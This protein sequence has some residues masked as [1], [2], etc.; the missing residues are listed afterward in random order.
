VPNAGASPLFDSAKANLEHV[1]QQLEEE[2]QRWRDHFKDRSISYY[3]RGKE[4]FQ[5]ELKLE[6]ISRG[7]VPNIFT[8]SSEAKGFKRFYTSRIRDLVKIH[9]DASEEFAEASMNVLRDIIARFDA[10]RDIWS[11]LVKSAAEVDALIGLAVA[12]L[13]DGTGPMVRPVVLPDEHAAAVFEAVQLRHPVLAAKAGASFVAND[14]SLGADHESIALVTGSNC[15]G[16]STLSRQIAVAVILAQVGVYVPARSLTMRPFNAIYARAG[17]RDEIARG[18][19]TFMV[20][21]EEA[22]QIVNTATERSLVIV[23]ELS[24]GTTAQDAHAISHATLDHLLR[25]GCLTV[26]CTHAD[27]LAVEFADRVGNYTMAADVDEQSKS[28]V[29]LYKLIRGVTNHSRGVFCARVAGIPVSIAD[30][31][32][33][34]A[35]RFDKSLQTNR[36]AFNFVNVTKALTRS[37]E[38]ALDELASILS[39]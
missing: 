30:E 33:Q 8:P 36:F 26:F 12:S 1:E 13:G 34:V 18:R 7:R 28:I 6:T 38:A 10:K 16:K 21:M 11:R 17:S 31:A 22:A 15:S 14:T 35:E 37:D 23:D 39:P 2:L 9:V 24:S 25:V 19:S 27:A 3:H 20:E 5:L 32:E 4:T 29:F